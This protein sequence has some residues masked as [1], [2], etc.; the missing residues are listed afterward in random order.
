[1]R[2]TLGLVDRTEGVRGQVKK[3]RGLGRN[4]EDATPIGFCWNLD[5]S[6]IRRRWETTVK[7]GIVLS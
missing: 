5:G 3:P 7:K 1:V 2:G 6:G 4:N